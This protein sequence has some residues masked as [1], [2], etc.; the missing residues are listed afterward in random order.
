MKPTR[1]IPVGAAAG[2]AT[3]AL[4][5][6]CSTGSAKSGATSAE[7]ASSTSL[8]HL[9]REELAAALLTEAELKGHAV[10][11]LVL[12]ADDVVEYS[13]TP[14]NCQPLLAAIATQSTGID[15]AVAQ[16]RIELTPHS[17]DPVAPVRH[18][19]TL[20]QLPSGQADKYM[21][22]VR[23]SLDACSSLSFDESWGEVKAVVTRVTAKEVGG[24]AIS[25]VI[26]TKMDVDG[27][28]HDAVFFPVTIVRSGT[29][30]ATFVSKASATRETEFVAEAMA[31]QRE[32]DDLVSEQMAKLNT[33][34]R[35]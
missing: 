2:A 31:K 14:A 5:C 23:R 22:S 28:E 8:P 4:L 32:P 21:S 29:V 27:T 33:A 15:A 9:S 1:R 24:E 19:I 35:R 11:T 13:A 20:S 6:G 34:Q 18:A 16:E 30:I 12:P 25:F 26:T 3:L 10:S 17:N 7:A